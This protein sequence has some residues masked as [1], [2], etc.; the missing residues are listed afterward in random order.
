MF[1]GKAGKKWDRVKDEALAHYNKIAAEG[2]NSSAYQQALASEANMLKDNLKSQNIMSKMSG[3][4]PAAQAIARQQALDTLADTTAKIGAGITADRNAAWDNYMNI[5]QNALQRSNNANAI[6]GQA[7]GSAI[8]S[9]IGA[10]TKLTSDL[11]SR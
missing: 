3:A 5:A 2:I 11:I 9:L 10:A 6:Q 8:S 1:F 4:T 7:G